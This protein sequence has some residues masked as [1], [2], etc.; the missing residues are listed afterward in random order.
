VYG[1]SRWLVRTMTGNQNFTL[2]MT[3]DHPGKKQVTILS[4][5]RE[6]GTVIDDTET[7]TVSIPLN[8]PVYE[9]T[10]YKIYSL[11]ISPSPDVFLVPRSEASII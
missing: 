6:T 3:S 4:E 11:T 7:G 9:D 5:F 10:G 2:T 8:H 1:T